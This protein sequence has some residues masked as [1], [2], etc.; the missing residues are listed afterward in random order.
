MFLGG[1][2]AETSAEP[3]W[4]KRVTIVT[5]SAAQEGDG[6]RLADGVI[7]AGG[8]D[9]RLYQAMVLSLSSPTPDSLCEKGTFASLAEI[10]T[11]TNACPK[12]YA[13][14][15]GQRVYLSGSTVHTSEESYVIGLGLLV[16]DE[17]HAAVYRLRV[18]GDSYDME[19]RSTATFDY[20]PVP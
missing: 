20:E 15:W 10:P 8:G 19:G 12:A 16:R 1:C 17:D 6:V 13:S 9:L 7:V 5:E 4:P 11:A 2:G 14:A 18:V 3:T